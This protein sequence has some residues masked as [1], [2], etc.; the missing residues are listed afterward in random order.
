MGV[1]VVTVASGGLPVIDVT[2]TKP[3]QGLPVTE[4][5]STPTKIGIA[6]TKVTIG[7]IAVTYVVPP[8]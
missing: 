8:L 6:V 7:G 5:T 2:A 1:A 3:G 4:S